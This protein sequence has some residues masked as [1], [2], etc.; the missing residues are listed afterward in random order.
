MI[1]LVGSERMCAGII[2][3]DDGNEQNRDQSAEIA[4]RCTEPAKSI[5]AYACLSLS[6]FDLQVFRVFFVVMKVDDVMYS[7]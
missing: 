6:L 5:Q 2:Y 3:S 1:D 4:F 7:M